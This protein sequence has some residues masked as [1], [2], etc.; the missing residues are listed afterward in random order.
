[1]NS[2]LPKISFN[3]HLSKGALSVVKEEPSSVRKYISLS[4]AKKPG[5]SP[6]FIRP[7]KIDFSRNLVNN[8]GLSVVEEDENNVSGSSHFRSNFNSN[9]KDL[10]INRG[11]SEQ[12]GTAASE[13][14]FQRTFS[15]SLSKGNIK[16]L[17]TPG[18]ALKQ[19]SFNTLSSK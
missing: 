19:T 15:Y 13:N 4:S 14:P 16:A 12:R 2:P 3:N 17:Q 8:L 10:L 7:N 5:F 6:N 9:T 1:M 18:N 11:M